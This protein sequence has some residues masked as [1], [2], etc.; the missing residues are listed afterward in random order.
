MK[1]NMKMLLGLPILLAFLMVGC[2]LDAP[3]Q[4]NELVGPSGTQTFANYASMGNSLTAGYQDGGLCINGQLAS[5]P[6]L[7]AQQMGLDVSVGSSDFT[8][9][10]IAM[11]GIGGSNPDDPSLID[12]VL[13]FDGESISVLGTQNVSDVMDPASPANP[14]L[15]RTLPV[16]YDNHGVPGAWTSDVMNAY[17]ATTSSPPG[18]TF[19]NFINRESLFGNTHVD[20]SAGPPATPAW[21]T[22]SMFW[23]TVAG[24]S[25][26]TT[27]WIGNNDILYGAT[28][29]DPVV[30]ENMTDAA[31]FQAEYT[32]LLGTLA[33]A[34]VQRTGYPT[35][36][37]VAN[38]PSISTIPYFIDKDFFEFNIVGQG[39]VSA[40]WPGG[41][42]EADV[43]MMTFRVLT[44]MSTP[45]GGLIIEGGEV[46]GY[47]SM[48][49]NYTLT[50]DEVAVVETHVATLNSI[51]AGVAV[52]VND[53][54]LAKVAMVDANALMVEIAAGT[55]EAGPLAATHFMFLVGQDNPLT[56]D[57]DDPMTV[58]QAAAATLFSLD[59]VHP[60]SRGYGVVANAFIEKINELQGTHVADVDWNAL[61]W[62]PTYGADIS[63]KSFSGTMPTLSPGAA[64]AMGAIWR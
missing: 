38:I 23:Q 34:M 16:P 30:G 20:A 17:D 58:E 29:G 3:D 35:T 43:A 63:G 41:Y 39:E 62:D 61:V 59:G 31:T 7:I 25:A 42:D 26:L 53:S 10:Y 54:G 32:A 37:I 13:H 21:E 36:I 55:H 40:P 24:G 57:V 27:M 49:S 33:G 1:T 48:P 9:P 4:S 28:D 45:G 46:V 44:W 51:I 60:N 15:L 22:S 6:R 47:N 2:T 52:G 11:P 64:H 12:G 5:Y 19:F 50:T 56:P 18:N 14:L 8:Q